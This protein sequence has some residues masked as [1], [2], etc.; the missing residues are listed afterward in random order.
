M[1]IKDKVDS[2][3]AILAFIKA[4][5]EKY[6]LPEQELLSMWVETQKTVGY[7]NGVFEAIEAQPIKQLDTAGLMQK[8]LQLSPNRTHKD[9]SMTYAE[10]VERLQGEGY[11]IYI[12]KLTVDSDLL[13]NVRVYPKSIRR[14]GNWLV[15][16]TMGFVG[17]D[18]EEVTCA[19][20]EE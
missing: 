7:V 15:E 6:V 16:I 2:A 20:Y 5:S 4:V 3:T 12:D 8:W 1:D 9:Y 17:Y 19:K 18:G 10:M 11:V 14:E 13:E